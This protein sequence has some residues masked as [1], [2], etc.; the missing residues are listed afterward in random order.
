MVATTDIF[1]YIEVIAECLN[2]GLP[3]ASFLIIG[4]GSNRT[5]RERLQLTHTLILFQSILGLIMSIC[6]VACVSTFAKGFVPIEIRDAH[7]E[8][9]RLVLQSLRHIDPASRDSHSDTPDMEFVTESCVEC[10]LRTTLGDCV[11]GC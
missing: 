6:F 8:Y 5:F 3:R 11:S 9:Y 4:D 7:V 2:E 10:A 1:T